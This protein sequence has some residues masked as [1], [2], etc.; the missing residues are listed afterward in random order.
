MLSITNWN[1][2]ILWELF[3]RNFWEAASKETILICWGCFWTPKSVD[4]LPKPA[5]SQRLRYGRQI[6]TLNQRMTT[7]YR[8]PIQIKHV[9]LKWP[10][11]EYRK[12]VGIKLGDLEDN[13]ST[14]AAALWLALKC[15]VH[16]AGQ[17]HPEQALSQGLVFWCFRISPIIQSFFW[18]QYQD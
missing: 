2:R 11:E 14:H 13:I 7:T 16:S 5:P 4:F 9:L 10:V 15:S 3:N 18:S 6:K 8:L 12:E 17:G 1:I